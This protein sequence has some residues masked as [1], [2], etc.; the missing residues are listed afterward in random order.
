MTPSSARRQWT[1]WTARH[2]DPT[3]AFLRLAGEFGV[4]TVDGPAVSITALGTW[5]VTR[6]LRAKTEALPESAELTPRQ[7]II[8]R[9]GMSGEAFERETSRLARGRGDR[10][11]P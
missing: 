9:L 5:A 11:G 8:C 4:V 1:S 7:L 2:G 3:V 10:T 6:E